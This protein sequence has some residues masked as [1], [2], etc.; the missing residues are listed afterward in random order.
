MHQLDVFLFSKEQ[1]PGL[2]V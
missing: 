1:L 2:E